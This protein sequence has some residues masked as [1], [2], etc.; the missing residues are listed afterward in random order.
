MSSRCVSHNLQSTLN[1]WLVRDLT[2]LK[3]ITVLKT[4]VIPKHIYKALHLPIQLPEKFV[5]N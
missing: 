3:R 1:V 2:L 5:S 4:L